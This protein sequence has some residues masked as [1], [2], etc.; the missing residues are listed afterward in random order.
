[1]S[2]QPPLFKPDPR[3][4]Q[5]PAPPAPQ[6]PNPPTGYGY[7]TYP[8]QQ[9]SYPQQ[10]YQQPI[11]PQQQ[12]YQLYPPPYQ[13]R[14][15]SSGPLPWILGIIGGIGAI[16]LL[17]LAAAL[18]PQLN[19]R[20]N[21]TIT[22]QPVQ[23]QP[24]ST[25]ANTHLKVGQS[26]NADNNWQVGVLKVQTSQGSGFSKADPGKIYVLVDVLL[27]NISQETQ[28]ASS[29][30]MWELRDTTGVRYSESLFTDAN[31]PG[32][33]AEPSGLVKG[34]LAYEVPTSQHQFTLTFSDLGDSNGTIW[35]IKA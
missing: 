9:P 12:P 35:D 15:K 19:T 17:C 30:F 24:T 13:P 4:N 20:S 14:K 34:T 26:I 6:Q 25:P 18:A 23:D 28:N 11:Y 10:P 22:T 29:L 5:P 31:S 3:W 32:G 33:K 8:Q 16:F 7:P 21:S 2:D 27:K 1:M